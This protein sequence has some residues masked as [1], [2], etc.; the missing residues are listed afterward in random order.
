MA[1]RRNFYMLIFLL[2]VL[3]WAEMLEFGQVFF[4]L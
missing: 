1:F 4:F 3:W 2:F